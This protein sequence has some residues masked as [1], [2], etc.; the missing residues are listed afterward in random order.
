[1][2]IHI[3]VPNAKGRDRSTRQDFVAMLILSGL[4]RIVVHL[5]VRLDDKPQSRAVEVDDKS[6]D[7]LLPAELQAP[8]PSIAN[9]LP[10]TAFGLGAAPPHPPGTLQLTESHGRTNHNR[11]KT[12]NGM[13]HV[14]QSA[15]C[16]Q[17]LGEI[18]FSCSFL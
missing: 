2:P 16:R 18:E 3:C 10:R 12:G 17:R 7:A 13:L 6:V 15:G 8:K 1:V 4:F 9:N 5:A 11:R 14:I